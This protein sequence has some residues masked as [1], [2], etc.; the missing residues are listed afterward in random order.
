MLKSSARAPSNIALI[1]YMGKKTGSEAGARANLPENPSLS[2]TLDR[3]CS[4]AELYFDPAGEP[5]VRWVPELPSFAG[6]AE[7]FTVP[8]L[9]GEAQARMRAYLARALALAPEMLARQG[10]SVDRRRIA[11]GAVE[12]RTANRFPAGA[13]IASSASSFAAV[14][15]A[16]AGLF[17]RDGRALS[18]AS[19]Q[20]ALWRELA[21]LS[22][23]GSGSS[24]RSFG[25]PWVLWESEWAG[26]IETRMPEL[27]DLIVLISSRP[28]GVPSSEAHR[29]VRTSPLW[30]GRAERACERLARMRSALE[31]G[32]LPEVARL[33]WDEAWEMHS[34]FHTA[35]EPFSYWEPGTVQALQFLAPF[36]SDP[37]PPIVT[38]DAGPNVHVLV[39]TV[40]AAAWRERLAAV[41]GR[42]RLLEDRQGPGAC[43]VGGL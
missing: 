33:A 9:D 16:A 8:E 31:R 24:C 18:E 30:N 1:K 34:L 2:L 17:A 35:A 27:T 43:W 19:R 21:S 41:F 22:R 11:E 6:E 37:R 7:G 4:C 12:L 10:V 5:G 26:E 39:E 36:L 28:K 23:S 40:G 20:G 32:E 14:T 29:R 13:G 42:E 15:L 38:L 3:L 25:G